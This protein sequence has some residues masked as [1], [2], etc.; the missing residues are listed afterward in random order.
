MWSW[1]VAAAPPSL[2]EEC[3]KAVRSTVKGSGPSACCGADHS[4]AF[5]VMRSGALFSASPLSKSLCRWASTQRPS[6]R[7][8]DP[9]SQPWRARSYYSHITSDSHMLIP[10]LLVVLYDK[11]VL[12]ITS[13]HVS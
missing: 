12:S 10:S 1:G 13:S 2:G 6:C 4:G 11:A 5:H 3:S 9:G 7:T 8:L